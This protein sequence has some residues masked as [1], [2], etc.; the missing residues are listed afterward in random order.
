[1]FTASEIYGATPLAPQAV[2]SPM[3]PLSSDD[4]GTGLKSLLD[5]KN[6]LTVFGVILAV[7]VG[8]AGVSGSARV[9]KF[10]ASAS[11]GKG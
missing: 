4:L 8:L 1:M 2:A 6:P 10:R 3:Q 7:T 11:A 9:G 5:P